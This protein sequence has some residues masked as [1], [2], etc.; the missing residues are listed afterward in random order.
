[1]VGARTVDSTPKTVT[2]PVIMGVG[3]P[4]SLRAKQGSVRPLYRRST[5]RKSR[6]FKSVLD[7][8]GLRVGPLWRR[9]PGSTL[10]DRGLA[11]ARPVRVLGQSPVIKRDDPEGPS[12]TSAGSANE[13]PGRPSSRVSQ[14]RVQWLF[15]P[16]KRSRRSR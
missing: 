6:A 15:C 4:E 1:V 12:T 8:P 11:L 5:R 10:C 16:V 2:K 13:D 14:A 3:I 7:S 9:S